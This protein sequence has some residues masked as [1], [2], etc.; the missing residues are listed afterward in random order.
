MSDKYG[1]QGNGLLPP[2]LSWNQMYLNGMKVIQT[3]VRGYQQHYQIDPTG[4]FHSPLPLLHTSVGPPSQYAGTPHVSGNHLHVNSQVITETVRNNDNAY[5]QDSKRSFDS[6]TTISKRKRSLDSQLA[7]REKKP[8]SSTQRRTSQWFTPP[9]NLAATNSPN[10]NT[11]CP[12]Q[13]RKRRNESPT[14]D[15]LPRKHRNYSNQGSPAECGSQNAFLLGGNEQTRINSFGP[16][17]INIAII[18][19]IRLDQPPYDMDE[20]SQQ[21]WN[22]YLQNR[23][24]PGDLHSKVLMRD[25]LFRLIV[26]ALPGITFGLHITGSSRNGFGSR[27][28]DL[29][30]CL[31]LAQK[32][33]LISKNVIVNFLNS[34]HRKIRN[35][36]P[37]F[38]RVMV[39]RARVPILRFS[40][41]R[42]GI[43]CDINI[44]NATGIR[45]T[46]LLQA[47]S[48]LDWR[49]SPLVMMIK[50]WASVHN[51]NDAS[52]STL[53]SYTLALMVLN[54]LQVGC[55][56]VVIPSLQE[57]HPED[58]SSHSEVRYLFTPNS[59]QKD[60]PEHLQYTSQNTQSLGELLKGFFH[61][62]A[63][64]FNFTT[65]VISVR[66]GS[67]YPKSKLPSAAILNSG[68]N[69]WNLLCVEEP[70]DLCNAARPVFLEDK[71]ALIKHILKRTSEKIRKAKALTA[72][73]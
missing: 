59:L 11:Y 35:N 68:R 56:P 69:E 1:R 16:A 62:Y 17:G 20:F 22:Y 53:S 34:I 26:L 60:L 7:Y 30:I 63:N 10:S 15:H 51:I 40:D 73:L 50:H 49:V 3:A 25:N 27:N 4:Q 71:F 43:D 36:R 65:H 57:L 70:F 72:I 9:P 55:Q 21:I 54:Y 67:T 44:N 2:P 12:T 38:T 18:R 6:D 23:Q 41:L 28:S 29:D 19:P 64:E 47:Y 32:N 37:S 5:R 14:E 66:L 46:Y 33:H 58:F 48:K 39:I 42:S 13:S 52:Q 61:Y 24:T 8:K 45:N 31:M